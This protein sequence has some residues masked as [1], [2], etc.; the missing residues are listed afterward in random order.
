MAVRSSLP[1]IYAQGA[2]ALI[3]R[4]RER[5]ESDGE[6]VVP[7]FERTIACC[8]MCAWQRS[9]ELDRQAE[10]HSISCVKAYVFAVF[11]D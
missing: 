7:P 6:S 11:I 1:L 10:M 5:S 9:S 3:D 2:G 4:A 8:R